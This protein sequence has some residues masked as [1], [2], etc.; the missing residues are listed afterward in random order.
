MFDIR[1]LRPSRFSVNRFVI[2]RLQFSP[3]R[4]ISSYRSTP[5]AGS[6]FRHYF[7]YVVYQC[8][9]VHSS[10]STKR[11][12]RV[13]VESV[14]IERSVFSVSLS[15]L[16]GWCISIFR[17]HIDEHL[18]VPVHA[19]HVWAGGA[20]FTE[21]FVTAVPQPRC[22]VKLSYVTKRSGL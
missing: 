7:V 11:H 19:D 15:V 12:L 21:N 1:S 20:R 17:F 16:L 10:C 18:T 3:K 2:S 22:Y 6:L 14:R 4:S 5:S 9:F 8:E 13:S